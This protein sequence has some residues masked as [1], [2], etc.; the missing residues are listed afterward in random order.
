MTEVYIKFN[1]KSDI[2][3]TIDELSQ[4]EALLDEVLKEIEIQKR[5]EVTPRDT[6][7]RSKIGSYFISVTQQIGNYIYKHDIRISNT[8]KERLKNFSY[9]ADKILRENIVL[10]SK[11]PLDVIKFKAVPVRHSY[12]TFGGRE[13]RWGYGLHMKPFNEQGHSI[14][15]ANMPPHYTQ[16]IHNHTLSEYCLILDSKTEGIYYPGGK[17]EKIYSTRKHELLHFSATT[18]HTLRNPSNKYSRNI[19]FKQSQGLVDWRPISSLN[20]VKIIRARL[21]RGSISK[22]NNDQ[23][24]KKFPIHDKYY[25]YA[26]EIIKLG[27]DTTYS[28]K[29]SNDQFIFVINGKFVISHKNIKKECRKNDFIVIDRDTE[30]KIETS[31]TCRLYSVRT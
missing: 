20:V 8:Y 27:K 1:R 6:L 29:H 24:I 23:T 9:K 25:N 11:P 26:L 10:Q 4:K 17:R 2:L 16:S 3:K 19:T 5:G 13:Q 30:Y 28:T 22:I 7:R 18:P 31:T 12:S 21:I 14:T 15:L